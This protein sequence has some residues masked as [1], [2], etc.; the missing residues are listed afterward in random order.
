MIQKHFFPNKTRRQVKLK[1]KK[2]ERE[3][4]LQLSDALNNHATG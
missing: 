1:F 2:E 4:P 3:H